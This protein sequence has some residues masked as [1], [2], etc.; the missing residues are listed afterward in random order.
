MPERCLFLVR[1]QP[2]ALIEAGEG[3]YLEMVSVSSANCQSLMVKP[4]RWPKTQLSKE[5]KEKLEPLVISLWDQSVEGS[6]AL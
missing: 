2:V 5:E 3:H 4:Q 6:K 1:T